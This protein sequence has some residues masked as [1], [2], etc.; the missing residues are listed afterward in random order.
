MFDIYLTSILVV[1]I[2]VSRKYV[3][4]YRIEDRMGPKGRPISDSVYIG[5]YFAYANQEAAL[6]AARRLPRLIAGATLCTICAMLPAC[7]YYRQLY[8]TIPMLLLLPALYLLWASVFRMKTA[9]APFIREDKDKIAVR[10]QTGA[11]YLLVMSVITA[12]CGAAYL[13]WGG[14]EG[15]DYACFGMELLR[16]VFA[17]VIFRLRKL[18]AMKE[19]PKEEASN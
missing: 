14:A 8:T 6:Q 18:P 10:M 15:W 3:K 12:L 5:S 16:I 13:I 1:R 19:L 9:K 2:L 7:R 11:A 4:D 17:A